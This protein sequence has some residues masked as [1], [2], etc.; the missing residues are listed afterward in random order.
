MIIAKCIVFRAQHLILL[1]FYTHILRESNLFLILSTNFNEIFSKLREILTA[2][3]FKRMNN[4]FASYSLLTYL[5]DKSQKK[6]GIST[7][8]F[9]C[10]IISKH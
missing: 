3:S 5:V 7:K 10:T 9:Y 2:D 6:K 8:T 4:K 1:S